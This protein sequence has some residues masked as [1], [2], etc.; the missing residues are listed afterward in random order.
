MRRGRSAN[1]AACAPLPSVGGLSCFGFLSLIGRT[2]EH[3]FSVAKGGAH[4]S[5]DHV[6][7]VAVL[8]HKRCEGCP[9]RSPCALGQRVVAREG[10]FECSPVVIMHGIS[11]AG[12]GPTTQLSG[13]PSKIRKERP[14]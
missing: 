13:H 10:V 3:L 8:H 2:L 14:F 6:D 12:S 11:K 5:C 1:H 9:A 7:R 4:V